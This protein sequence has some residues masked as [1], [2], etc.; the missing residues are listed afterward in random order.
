MSD[1]ADH[2]MSRI[3]LMV[4]ISG[5]IRMGSETK[6]KT[7]CARSKSAKMSI[8]FQGLRRFGNNFLGLCAVMSRP[9]FIKHHQRTYISVGR[10]VPALDLEHGV[11]GLL[12]GPK[13][14]TPSSLLWAL[15]VQIGPQKD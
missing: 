15:Y 8:S 5:P 7:S 3:V 14:L 11:V 13:G 2:S 12:N 9:K 4:F 1:R 10:A 6:Y